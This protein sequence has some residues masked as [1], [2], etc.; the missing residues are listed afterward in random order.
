M[1]FA[2]KI[3][4]ED[5]SRARFAVHE[6]RG[7]KLFRRLRVLVVV[8]TG[9]RVTQRSLNKFVVA[10]TGEPLVLVNA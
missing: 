3:T 10:G 4:V 9:A 7:K 1:E 8:E 2:G 6:Y 5:A